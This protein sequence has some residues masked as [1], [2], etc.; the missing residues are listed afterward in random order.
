M[1]KL[2]MSIARD[3]FVVSYNVPVSCT[4]VSAVFAALVTIVV[5]SGSGGSS[6]INSSSDN[7]SRNANFGD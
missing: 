1:A 2:L 5:S 6:S 4:V 7:S 3:Y